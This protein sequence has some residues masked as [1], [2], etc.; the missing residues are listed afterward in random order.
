MAKSLDSYTVKVTDTM[1][2]A[3]LKITVNKHRAVVVLDGKKVVG[4]V[5]DGDLRRAALK[6]ILPIAP[7]EEIMNLNCRTTMERDSQ[8]QAEILQ[9][10]QVT[11]MPVIDENNELVDVALAYEPFGHSQEHRSG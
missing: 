1:Q 3:M 8:K 4:T 11:L 6:G 2:T 9:R 7:V 10:E 5:S